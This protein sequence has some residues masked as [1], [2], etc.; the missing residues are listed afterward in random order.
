MYV[1]AHITNAINVVGKWNSC[2]YIVINKGITAFHVVFI[3]KIKHN[4]EEVFQML[5]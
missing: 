4:K 1:T 5:R 2:Y 3:I